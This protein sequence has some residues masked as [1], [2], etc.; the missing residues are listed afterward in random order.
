MDFPKKNYVE[1]LD[2]VSRRLNGKDPLIFLIFIWA[3]ESLSPVLPCLYV[4]CNINDRVND[5][6]II[7]Y[8]QDIEAQQNSNW[9]EFLRFNNQYF[10]FYFH[11]Y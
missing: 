10:K 3:R 11:L 8:K 5:R 2:L 1:I 6:D 9:V 7:F 4:Y